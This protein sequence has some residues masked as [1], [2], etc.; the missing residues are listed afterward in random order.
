[1]PD[2]PLELDGAQ[3]AAL[4]EAVLRFA[5]GFL[6]EHAD[7]P[8]VGGALDPSVAATLS[9]PPP[10]PG[11]PVDE[12]LAVVDRATRAGLD[13]A[14]GRFLGY[15]PSGGLF[16]AAIGTFLGAVTNQYTGGAHAAP[17]LVALEESVLTWMASLFDLPADA[18]GLLVSGGSIANLTAMVTARHA[19]GPD[20]DRGV[21]YTSAR[22]H[23]SIAKAARIAGVAPDRV[24]HVPT[25]DRQR[26]D[27]AALRAAIADDRA[28]G[29]P[30]MLVAATAGTT[31]TGA[32]DPLRACA[33]VA[34]EHGAWFHVDGAYGGFFALTDRGRALFDGI[35]LAD[36]I[37]VDAHKSLFLPFG[38]GGLLVR[39]TSRLVDAHEGRGAYMRDVAETVV[40]H[41][42]ARGP[43]LT[44]PARGLTVWTALQLHGVAAF[45][46]TLDRMLDLAGEAADR[47]AAVDGIELVGR[48]TLSIVV[49]RARDDATTTRVQAA[50]NASGQV[51]VS[52]TTIDDRVALRF[53]L[54]SQ[55]THRA[56]VHAAVEVVEATLRG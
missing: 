30:P 13:T 27:V 7:G 5:A 52:S 21:V 54:L 18:G 25:D 45:R 33:G 6:D 50:L 12:V 15:I 19:A 39:D 17:G 2:D 35:E 10:D 37:T 4:G 42:L 34:R 36:S 1:M 8:P 44:R 28:S 11:V 56:H 43:E 26:L 20:A 32:V 14:S 9:A 24:R 22:A 29:H 53:A 40:P 47:L 48:P 55:R 41:Y 31:D 3:R 46:D 51:Y 16:A 23:H 38:V 49:F